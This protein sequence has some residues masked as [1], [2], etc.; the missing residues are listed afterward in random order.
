MTNININKRIKCSCI[1]C[2]REISVSNIDRHYQSK[3]CK[4]GLKNY[5]KNFKFD[6]LDCQFCGK[7]CKNHNSIR[8][9]VIRCK[10]NPEKINISCNIQ[11]RKGKKGE[12]QYTKA[13]R[14]G[15]PVPIVSDITKK[16]ISDNNT[17]NRM[18]STE[19]R[20]QHS[21]IMKLAAINNPHSYS[22]NYNRGKVKSYEYLGFTVIGRWELAFVQYCLEKCIQIVQ[23]NV[24]FS[25]EWNESIH[26]Y[27]PDFYLPEYDIY[28]EVKG[29]FTE[30]DSCKISQFPH[31]LKLIEKKEIQ[32][33]KKGCFNLTDFL[34]GQVGFEPTI[35][36]L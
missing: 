22:G 21:K 35:P 26:V 15:L 10:H 18:W 11:S 14:L 24:P 8:Q 27:F 30:R 2:K 9:H 16:K 34:V 31:K 32:K 29:Y 28:I 6:G 1:Q 17:G 20:L 4:H 23:P 3:S 13:K 33:I 12:N 19:R 5:V 7:Q 36:R 25:Y